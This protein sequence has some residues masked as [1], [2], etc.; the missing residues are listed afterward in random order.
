MRHR[1]A[2]LACLVAYGG[3]VACA[4]IIGLEPAPTDGGITTSDAAGGFDATIACSLDAQPPDGASDATY[5]P[6]R[7]ILVDDAGD[8]TFV[9]FDLGNLPN[10]TLGDASV[11][12]HGGTFD[13]TNVYFT[14]DMANGWIVRHTTTSAI[15]S[16]WSAFNPGLVVDG[17]QTYEGATFDGRYVYFAPQ[18]ENATGYALRYDSKSTFTDPASWARF[19]TST[20][21]DAG[22]PARGFSGAVFDGRYVYY[23][24]YRSGAI[25]SG[26]VTRY[27]TMAAAPDG[28]TVDAGDAGDAGDAA[29]PANA[30]EN[31]ASWSTFDTTTVDSRASGYQ[32]G[33]FDGR[34][35][36]FIPLHGV[37]LT[38]YDTTKMFRSPGSWLTFEIDTL[39]GTPGNFSGAVYDGHYL[40]LIPH[41]PLTVRFEPSKGFTASAFTEFSIPTVVP[42]LDSGNYNFAGGAFDG[43]YVYY[44]P[45]Y[46]SGAEVLRYDTWS[47]FTATCSWQAYDVATINPLVGPLWGAVYD[48][49]FLYYVPSTPQHMVVVR[50]DTKSPPSMPKLPAFSGSFF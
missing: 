46:G 42:A 9:L 29:A 16:A 38:A 27:D 1:R 13:G 5:N 4:D 39:A 24:P 37:I 2:V 50:Y 47:P 28:G 45:Q 26:T 34:F 23:V 36:Y 35:V 20:S 43:R 10:G 33:V 25:Y 22:L 32:G 31:A 12:F 41:G 48:G 19:D 18:E 40:Y 21:S 8:H 7:Q 15:D 11:L 49:Q 44:V 17:G 14:P 30:F 3:L 6:F